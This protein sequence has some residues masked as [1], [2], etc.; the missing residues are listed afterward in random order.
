MTPSPVSSL[1]EVAARLATNTQPVFYVSRTATHLIGVEKFVPGLSF[2]TLV[3]SWNGA[4]PSVFVPNNVPTPAPRG[5][6]A[7]INWML[8]NPVVLQHMRDRTPVGMLPQVMLAFFDET[9]ERLCREAGLNLIMPS[10]ELRHRLDSKM[11]TTELGESVGV[12]SVP[13]VI[14]TIDS[15]EALSK[16]ALENNLGADLVVQTAYGNSGETTYFIAGRSDYEAVAASINGVTVKIM[17]RINHLP[18]AVDAIVTSSGTVVGPIL[19]E[20][21]GHRELTEHTG[22]W[23]G[24][25]M[26]PSVMTPAARQQGVNMVRRF[27]D[28]L[29]EEGYRGTF[30]IDLLIDTDTDTVYLGELNP[31]LTGTMSITNIP[32]GAFSDLPLIALHLMEYSS[33]GLAIDAEAICARSAEL[34]TTSD[35]WSHMI[36]RAVDA[37]PHRILSTPQTG[38][39]RFD[40]ATGTLSFLREAFDWHGLGVGE[41]FYLNTVTAGGFST[42]GTDIGI[43]YA[44]ERV[45]NNERELTPG[46]QALIAAAHRLYEMRPLTAVQNFAR[47][48][49]LAIAIAARR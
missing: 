28:R 31:R 4:H 1:A 30:G 21:T 9:S 27:G 2:I 7:V 48:A 34:G 20:V 32:T 37:R 5:N 26:S 22:G 12:M 41:V 14:T 39:Y 35:E 6:I 3:D 46:G 36:I 8:R 13:N 25:E 17:K 49:R 43:V 11:V 24:N 44:R 16:A 18:L 23:S 33:L 19:S 15:W 38:I 10:D 47:K 29:A 40:E 42:R 45:Q